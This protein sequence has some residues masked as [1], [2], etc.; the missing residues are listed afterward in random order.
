MAKPALASWASITI[1][2]RWNDFFWPL[3]F[4][5][6]SEKY[7]LM[8]SVSMLPVSE[9]LS[10]PW[11]VLAGTSLVIVPSIILYLFMQLYQQADLVA[12]AVKD[13]STTTRCTMSFD[14]E[15]YQTYVSILKEELI[16]AVV[17]RSPPV[18]LGGSKTRDVLEA[19][20][21][22]VVVRLSANLIKNAKSVFIPYSE[23]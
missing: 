12:G 8:V 20:P 18:W 6:A 23:A 5:R 2:A 19:V 1:I 4:L 21:D 15:K 14:R 13:K 7:T 17:A 22:S 9:G 11:Q 10:T 3:L 16:P